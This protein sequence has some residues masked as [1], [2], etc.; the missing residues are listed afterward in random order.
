LAAHDEPLLWAR[1]ED[2]YWGYDLLRPRRSDSLN[3]IPH[4]D[5]P[6]VRKQ[7]ALGEGAWARFFANALARGSVS[8]LSDGEWQ[9][10]PQDLPSVLVKKIVGQRSLGYVQWDFGD[11]VYP[12]TLREMSAPDSGR[13]KAWRKHVRDGAL[14][15]ILLYWVS[16]LAAHVVL[17]GHDRLLAAAL[18]DA[19]VKA[20]GLVRVIQYETDPAIKDAVFRQVERALIAADRARSRAMKERLARV[21]RFM[22]VERANRLLLDVFLPKTHAGPTRALPLEG[23]VESWVAEVQ[24]E[25]A[26]QGAQ[27]EGLLSGLL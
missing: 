16:G 3:V 1:I 5:F 13:V 6:T 18:D 20:L 11:E 23:G 14:P 15:P 27:S 25:L 19:P 4:I 21:E 24:R 9:L 2:D 7:V 8:P 26:S 12:I 22:S 10:E 17:D